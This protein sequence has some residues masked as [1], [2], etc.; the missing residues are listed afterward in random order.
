M[1]L[2]S[3]PPWTAFPAVPRRKRTRTVEAPPEP[4]TQLAN[5]QR[6]LR[7]SQRRLAAAHA[8]RAE[9]ERIGTELRRL[10]EG[11]E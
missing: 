2:A 5:A 7:E 3:N 4:S 9:A 8:Q 11:M 1:S 10:M 6:E